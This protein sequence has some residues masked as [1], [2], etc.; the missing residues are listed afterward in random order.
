MTR[1]WFLLLA[2]CGSATA[3]RP[4]ARP[5]P[6]APEL[7]P[8]EKGGTCPTDTGCEAVFDQPGRHEPPD[9][10]SSPPADRAPN[11][12]G[13]VAPDLTCA[14]VAEVTASFEVGNYA[15][16]DVR[17]AAVTKYEDACANLHLNAEERTCVVGSRDRATAL[18]C[19]PRLYPETPYPLVEAK[20]CA[21]IVAPMRKRAAGYKLPAARKRA[22]DRRLEVIEGSC[23]HDRWPTALGVCTQTQGFAYI[24]Y[25]TQPLAA[26]WYTAPEPLRTVLSAKLATVPPAPMPIA[27]PPHRR[28][29]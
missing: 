28:R 21:A 6:H 5:A 16:P 13:P 15:E 27:P 7:H 22:V 8:I 11:D 10:T 14:G 1:A 18:Y 12:G 17:A 3:T 19:V 24:G 26:C 4:T 25:E 29:R 20:A 2:A 23:K 9:D